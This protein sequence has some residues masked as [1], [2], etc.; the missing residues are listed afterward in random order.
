MRIPGAEG[1]GTTERAA[2]AVAVVCCIVAVPMV[3]AAWTWVF[4]GA[5]SAA[6][7]LALAIQHRRFKRERDE[8]CPLCG[9]TDQAVRLVSPLDPGTRMCGSCYVRIYGP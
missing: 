4:A 1:A 7:L 2:V 5:G 8:A 6:I 3:T 9:R